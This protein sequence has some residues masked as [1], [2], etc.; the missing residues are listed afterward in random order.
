VPF[1]NIRSNFNKSQA[2]VSCDTVRYWD[3]KTAS[4]YAPQQKKTGKDGTKQKTRQSQGFERV[5]Y[6]PTG[7]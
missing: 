1:K 2:R 7:G 5:S 4:N 3:L 6:I